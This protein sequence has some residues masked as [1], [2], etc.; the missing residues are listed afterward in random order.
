LN[1]QNEILREADEKIEEIEAKAKSAVEEAENL[2]K[3]F[4]NYERQ[5]EDSLKRK[6][7]QMIQRTEKDLNEIQ[8]IKDRMRD[9][10]SK[11]RESENR[12]WDFQKEAELYKGKNKQHENNI[13]DLNAELAEIGINEE[14]ARK[15]SLGQEETYLGF[16][17]KLDALIKEN[18]QLRS[19]L[20]LSENNRRNSEERFKSRI[21]EIETVILK[22]I[23]E[24]IVLGSSKGSGKTERNIK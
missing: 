2:K 5:Y 21:E 15:T 13:K 17:I 16:R 20:D 23:N 6:D 11:L 24:I 18:E 12:C 3:A 7:E 10:E 19:E 22:H 4:N 1:Q 8:M 9:L 14:P